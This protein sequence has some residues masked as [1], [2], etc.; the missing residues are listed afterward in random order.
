VERRRAA[1]RRRRG[2]GIGPLAGTTLRRAAGAF[3][4]ASAALL[5]GLP[6]VVEGAFPPLEGVLALA[7]SVAALEALLF[8]PLLLPAAVALLA[9]ELVV[10]VHRGGLALWTVPLL[11]IGLL[12]VYEAGELRHRLP[13]DSVVERGPLRALASRLAL[14]AALGLLASGA[15]LA[16]GSLSSRGG[17]A[18]AVVGGLAATAAVLLVKMLASERR[19][20]I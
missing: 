19:A 15:V 18:A 3:A 1:R 17:A 10:S 12:L 7:A 14:T 8:A 13:P 2:A 11:A 20:T 16:A 9:T 4:A 5:A 6:I